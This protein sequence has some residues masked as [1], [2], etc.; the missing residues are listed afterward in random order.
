VNT[1]KAQTHVE[2]IY[3]KPY[4]KTG[5]KMD[6]ERHI[7]RHK[8]ECWENLRTGIKDKK[9]KQVDKQMGKKKAYGGE[10]QQPSPDVILCGNRFIAVPI[11]WNILSCFV[12]ITDVVT[13]L[14][15]AKTMLLRLGKQSN[16]IGDCGSIPN[17]LMARNDQSLDLS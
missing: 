10:G 12:Y 16:F 1:D 11:H 14:V 13:V 5:V 3:E 9:W 7:G 8:I 17:Q 6:M 4:I 2:G 15:L